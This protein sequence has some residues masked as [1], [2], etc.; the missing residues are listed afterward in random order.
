MPVNCES[1]LRS[2]LRDSL[3]SS[4][5]IFHQAIPRPAS[6]S[7]P[8]AFLLPFYLGRDSVQ[9]LLGSLLI[10]WG[11]LPQVFRSPG[12][13]AAMRDL[14]RVRLRLRLRGS[15][16]SF[17]V[18]FHQAISRPA[19]TSRLPAFLLPFYLGRVRFRCRYRT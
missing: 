16:L 18:I 7:C 10:T 4:V 8:P 17:V 12:C 1:V 11:N 19:S 2:E 15:L 9:R 5:V 3:F 13:S 6:T 14:G